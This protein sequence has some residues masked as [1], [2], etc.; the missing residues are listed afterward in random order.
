MN[1]LVFFA[2]CQY[3]YS[4]CICL[5]FF[6]TL[7]ICWYSQHPAQIGMRMLLVFLAQCPHTEKFKMEFASI[8]FHSHKYLQYFNVFGNN[9]STY[10][11]HFCIWKIHFKGLVP[12]R[13]K[14]LLY[15]HIPESLE[16]QFKNKLCCYPTQT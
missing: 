10:Q 11:K 6:G 12:V 3:E 15:S 9:M 4:V 16:M 2:F 5:V 1:I 7:N 8:F 13:F 14:I